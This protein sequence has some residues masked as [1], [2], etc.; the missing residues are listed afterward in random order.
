[1]TGDP[2]FNEIFLT[3]VRVPVESMLGRP[4]EGWTVAL[5]TLGHERASIGSMLTAGLEQELAAL[6]ELA[7]EPVDGSRPVD[8]PAL[9]TR[10]SEAWIEIRSLSALNERILADVARTGVPGPEASIIKL[11]CSEANQR[12]GRL[13]L[14]VLGPAAQVQDATGAGAGFWQ[15]QQLRSRGNTIEGGTSEILRGIVAER[16][17][18]LPRAGR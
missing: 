12:L 3:D 6:L 4:G 16:V 1:M 7:N 9:R 15:Y 13:A 11:R 18:G 8:D 5:T 14:D 10:L 17:L 2:E